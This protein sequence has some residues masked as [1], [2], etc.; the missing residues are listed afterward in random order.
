MRHG[1]GLRWWFRR[2]VV[3]QPSEGEQLVREAEAFLSGS[4]AERL[5]SSGAPVPAWAL[6]N[7]FAHGGIDALRPSARRRS[8]AQPSPAWGEAAQTL[9][10]ELGELVGGDEQL[11]RQVQRLVLVPLELA[12]MAEEPAW[13]GPRTVVNWTRAA[14]RAAAA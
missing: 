9:A 12:L 14:L 4:L 8:R 2:H 7:A 5:A 6:L 10:T 11:Y 3:A 1:R 13:L